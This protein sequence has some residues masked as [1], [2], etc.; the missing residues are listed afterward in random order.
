MIPDFLTEAKAI[1]PELIHLRRELH[2]WPELGN[3]EYET[4]S[5]LEKALRA[6]GVETVRLL[7]TAVV[8]TLRGALP[9]PAVALRA[10]MD[11]LP[12]TEATGAPFASRR[13]GVMHGCGHDVH[14]TA[15][16]GAAKL[17]SAHRDSLPGTVKF[18]FQPDE[19]G[20]GGAARMIAAGC[21]E[22]VGAVFG[23]HVSPALPLGTVGIRYGKFYAASD[24][25][26]IAVQGRSAHG[27]ERE[28][29]VD[30]LAAAAEMVTA[31]L[32]LPGEEAER[33]VISVGKLNAG[34]ARNILADRA[35]MDG[36]LRTLGP[37][38][39]AR[40]K[41]RLRETLEAIS[42]R[43]GTTLEL[44][45]WESYGGVVN[46]EAE[47][48]LLQSTVET[49]L[50]S[51]RVRVLSD[52]TLTTEDFGCFIDAAAGSYYHVGAGCSE[53]LHSP[54]FLPADGAE[55]VAAAVHAA[56][57]WAWL[58]ARTP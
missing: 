44:R 12:L 17:L 14:M 34:T 4:A 55:T 20:N 15:A 13:E 48:A 24:I 10:D 8:G 27:A 3:R 51:E 18:F 21:M 1:S 31:L 41:Q 56:A 35:E 47:T 32:A 9:G 57:A 43:H 50:G 36:I 7:D 39:R 11:A 38:A 30:A 19:E 54:A 40:I 42:A 33:C 28:L 45:L 5:R 58:T 23:C 53:P 49:L 26:Q 25:F 2:Q 22:G 29:G 37:E 16:L 6:C 52:P 46:S